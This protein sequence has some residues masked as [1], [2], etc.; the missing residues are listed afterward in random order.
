MPKAHR[1]ARAA[2]SCPPRRVFMPRGFI[3]VLLLTF[4]MSSAG[5]ETACD[6]RAPKG[7]DSESDRA[8]HVAAAR[9]NVEQARADAAAATARGEGLAAAV[10]GATGATGRQLVRQLIDSPAFRRVTTIGRRRVTASMIG[11]APAAFDA[12]ESSGKL[13]Q[14]EIAWNRHLAAAATLGDAGVAWGARIRQLRNH[15]SRARFHPHTHH[16]G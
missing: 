2:V 9:A 12:A 8:D 10:V 6:A 1:A 14:H 4:I 5:D 3:A 16:Q 13:V 15:I 11:L 7:F